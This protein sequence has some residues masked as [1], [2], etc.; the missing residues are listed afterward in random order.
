MPALSFFRKRHVLV[1]F[2]LP[3]SRDICYSTKIQRR[4]NSPKDGVSLQAGDLGYEKAFFDRNL[5]GRSGLDGVRGMPDRLSS[6]YASV[7]RDG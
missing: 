7:P 4:K 3:F 5:V 1:N 6:V 2:L